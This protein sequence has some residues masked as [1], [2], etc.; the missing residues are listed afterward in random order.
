VQSSSW[1]LCVLVVVRRRGGIQ[2]SGQH[3]GAD[4]HARSSASRRIVHRPVTAEAISD[5]FLAA[6]RAAGVKDLHFHDL[7]H[8]AASEMVNA[9]VPL[10]TVGAVLG[11]RDARSTKRKRRGGAP[12]RPRSTRPR[13]DPPCRSRAHPRELHP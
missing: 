9:G 5:G 13:D 1:S 7:R 2:R 6:C 8:S 10:H 3:I 4:D 11:H 12:Q